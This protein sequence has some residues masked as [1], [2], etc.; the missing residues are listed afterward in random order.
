MALQ[1][2]TYAN[3]L[4]L[5]Q[6]K[7]GVS[8]FTTNE[9]TRIKDLVNS[10]IKRAYRRSPY[11][12]NFLEIGEARAVDD[13][14]KILPYTGAVYDA[15]EATTPVNPYN[16]RIDSVYRVH[17]SAPFQNTRAREF[18]YQGG[19]TGV[20]LTNYSAVYGLSQA[21]TLITASGGTVTVVLGEEVDYYVGSS[22]ELAGVPTSPE[23]INGTHTITSVTAASYTLGLT[24][25][26]FTITNTGSLVWIMG[27]DETAKAPIVY[28][29]YKGRLADTY[30]DGAGETSAIP[31]LWFEYVALGVK[32]DLLSGDGSETASMKAEKLADDA[33]KDDLVRLDSQ[34][35]NQVLFQKIRTHGSE[36]TQSLAFS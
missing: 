23:D 13:G 3:L 24:T 31:E 10:R 17:E 1:T 21:P 35:A 36:S 15:T 34:Q 28:A 5:I 27:G 11:W 20:H 22:I 14:K 7:M 9:Q 26:R 12:E 16:H 33:L 4:L 32:A 25:V 19:P 18:L 30:G 29:S 6:A 2:D 8:S